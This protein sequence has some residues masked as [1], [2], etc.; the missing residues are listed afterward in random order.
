MAR[1]PGKC[2][3]QDDSGPCQTGGDAAAEGGV[4]LGAPR[5]GGGHRR[6]GAAGR[7][8]LIPGMRRL[9]SA[10][11]P[12]QLPGPRGEDFGTGGR[13]PTGT[14]LGVR[15]RRGGVGELPA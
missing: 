15:P 13:I 10:G 3:T 6:S 12:S 11:A 4:L 5:A 1:T 7:A 9:L 2:Q 8:A 14:S